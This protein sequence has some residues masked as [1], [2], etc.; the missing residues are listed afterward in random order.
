MEYPPDLLEGIDD[1][2]EREATMARFMVL[3]ELKLGFTDLATKRIA[4]LEITERE[5]GEDKPLSFHRAIGKTRV[6]VYGDLKGL[7]WADVELAAEQLGVDKLIYEDSFE[8]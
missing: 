2:F 7:T 1:E 5:N 3:Q 6:G 8:I 4:R